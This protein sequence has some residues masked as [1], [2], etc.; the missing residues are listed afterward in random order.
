MTKL[1]EMSIYTTFINELTKIF[2]A[3]RTK[4]AEDARNFLYGNSNRKNIISQEL[5]V[6]DRLKQQ[7]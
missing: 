6:Q 4:C 2:A 7:S 3:L 1:R 5:V